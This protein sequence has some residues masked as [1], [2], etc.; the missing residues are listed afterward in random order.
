MSVSTEPAPSGVHTGVLAVTGW[1]VLSSVGVGADEFAASV[2]SGE[3]RPADVS[4]MFEEPL[5]RPDAHAL[6]DFKVRDHLGR[7]GTSFFDRSTALAIVTG[8]LAIADTDLV[9]SDENRRRIGI[10]LGTTAGSVRSTSDYSRE[11]F[12]QSR[13]YLVN[14]LLFP[15]A[16]MNCAAGQAAIWFGLKGVNATIAGGQL[17]GLNVLRYG[18]N[19][20]SCGYADA[21]LIGA[22]EEFSPHVSWATHFSMQ[23][24]GGNTATGE[25]AAVFVVED[26]GAVRAAGRTPEAEILAAEVGSFT[27][28]GELTALSDGLTSLIRRALTRAGV[29]A[30]DV[31]GVATAENGILDLDAVEDRAVVAVL[32]TGPERIRVKQL[33]GECHSVTGGFQLAYVLARHRADPA[34]DGRVSVLTSRSSDGAVGVAVVRGYRR[35]RGHHGQ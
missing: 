5:P 4:T 11:T 22:V 2:Q 21:L 27:P 6:V 23:A 18:R 16:V 15:N 32:G 28:T 3:S 24:G 17:A 10:T 12:V 8:K 14:P 13:P 33:V 19:L 29:D 34:L 26:A 9:I 7:K 35:E 25:G 1:S 30:G 31:W 20:I